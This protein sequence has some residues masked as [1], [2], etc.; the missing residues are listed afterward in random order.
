[1]SPQP[2]ALRRCSK[3]TAAVAT[4]G[5]GLHGF[6]IVERLDLLRQEL[7]ALDLRPLPLAGLVDGD[8][9]WRTPEK[10]AEDR[11][12]EAWNREMLGRQKQ[13]TAEVQAIGE[14]TRV[15]LPMF[16]GCC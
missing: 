4:C 6:A 10:I 12:R 1:M 13:G 2:F 9:D 5:L 15:R 8:T 3:A 14:W 16:V 7:H 11:Q